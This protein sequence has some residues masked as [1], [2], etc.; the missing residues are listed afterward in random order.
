[1]AD[2]LDGEYVLLR[3]NRT[4]QLVMVTLG[5]YRRQAAR[6]FRNWKLARG[7]VIPRPV[8]TV[9]ECLATR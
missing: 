2:L 6:R 1:M 9:S 7:N 3:H 8:L 5:Q 4:E